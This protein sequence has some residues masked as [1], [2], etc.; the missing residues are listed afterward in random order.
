[1]TQTNLQNY[2]NVILHKHINDDRSNI[3][4]LT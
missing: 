2:N 4:H 3:I 1:M